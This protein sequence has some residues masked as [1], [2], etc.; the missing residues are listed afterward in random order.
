[1][2]IVPL[3]FSN[4]NCTFS[5]F[6]IVQKE[7]SIIGRHLPL[8]LEVN[9]EGISVADTLVAHMCHGTVISIMGPL[10]S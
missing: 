1:M 4:L 5:A 8:L 3:W 2:L 9:V 10:C 7:E 6:K